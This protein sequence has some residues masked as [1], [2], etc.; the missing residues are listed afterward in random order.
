MDDGHPEITEPGRQYATSLRRLA[1]GQCRWVLSTP[2]QRTLYC[3]APA[4]DDRWC[5]WH[6]RIVYAKPAAAVRAHLSFRVGL[7]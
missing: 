6:R 5:A 3:G 7:S 4:K 1:F 2:P